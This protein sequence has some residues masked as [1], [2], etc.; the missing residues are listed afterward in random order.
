ML[1]ISTSRC[2]SSST[3]ILFCGI[4]LLTWNFHNCVHLSVDNA[5]QNKFRINYTSVM[6]HKQTLR[7]ICCGQTYFG[8]IGGI[9]ENS[10]KQVMVKPAAR[11]G[12]E[13]PGHHERLGLPSQ[14]PIRDCSRNNVF[15]SRLLVNNGFTNKW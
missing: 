8:P 14:P 6:V 5:I 2:S 1:Q 7:I 13:R 3:D 10:K 12:L 15:T 9:V 4:S 11:L